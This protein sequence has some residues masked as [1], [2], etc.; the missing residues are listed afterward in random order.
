MATLALARRGQEADCLKWPCRGQGLNIVLV[1]GDRRRVELERHVGFL[2][3]PLLLLH[4]P[5]L[6]FPVLFLLLLLVTPD[7]RL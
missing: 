4:L 3:L 6:L 1:Q 7:P 5:L 2:N